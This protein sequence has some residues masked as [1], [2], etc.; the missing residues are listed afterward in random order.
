MKSKANKVLRRWARKL[1]RPRRRH[2]DYEQEKNE[3]HL[4]KP[5]AETFF[6]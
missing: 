2:A 5:R 1:E 4:S 3:V 6:I